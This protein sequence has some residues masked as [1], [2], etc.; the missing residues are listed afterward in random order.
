MAADF[1]SWDACMMDEKDGMGDGEWGNTIWVMGTPVVGGGC[2]EDTAPETWTDGLDA[3][4]VGR[5]G[6][7][8]SSSEITRTEAGR[9]GMPP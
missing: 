1:G 9:A 5:A 2:W 8:E 4:K 7:A 6:G 3:G